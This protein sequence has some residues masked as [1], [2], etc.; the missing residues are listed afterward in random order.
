MM[1][2]LSA[3]MGDDFDALV[4]GGAFKEPGK[5]RGSRFDLGHRYAD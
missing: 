2:D 3:D 1:A 4:A 5:R